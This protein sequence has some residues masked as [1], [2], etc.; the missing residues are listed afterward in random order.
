MI[1][2]SLNYGLNSASQLTPQL[3][4]LYRRIQ[5]PT[6]LT[7]PFA[8]ISQITREEGHKTPNLL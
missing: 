1:L 6:V 2:W 8:P 5:S 7:S 4:S 3:Y